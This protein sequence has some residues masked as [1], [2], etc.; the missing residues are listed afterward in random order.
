MLLMD[1]S[2]SFIALIR[3]LQSTKFQEQDRQRKKFFAEKSNPEIIPRCTGYQ[4]WF[5]ALMVKYAG[6]LVAGS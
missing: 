2:L 5:N 6:I 4:S 3:F 1:R